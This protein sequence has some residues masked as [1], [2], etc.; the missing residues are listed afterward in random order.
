MLS[1]IERCPHSKDGLYSL[2]L[3]SHYNLPF[4]GLQA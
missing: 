2:M 1:E 4:M 3:V